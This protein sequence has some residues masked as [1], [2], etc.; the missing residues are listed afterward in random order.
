VINVKEEIYRNLLRITDNIT[1]TYPVNWE[2]F[3]SI[4]YL[5]EENTP[6][7]IVDDNET[8]SYVRYR[9]DIWS[10]EST[11][12]MAIAVNDVFLSLGL[13]RTS[14]VDTP[15]PDALKHKVMRFEG[16]IDINTM[17]VHQK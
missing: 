8:Q 15:E 3:P 2:N 11:S 4:Q 14:C 1:D 17:I 16:V 10:K 6:Y 7:E 13:K 9:V 5:E 12:N